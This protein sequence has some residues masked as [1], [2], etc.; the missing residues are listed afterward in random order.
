MIRIG[1][2]A[3]ERDKINTALFKRHPS[4]REGR[5]VCVPVHVRGQ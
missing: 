1:V 2:V 4:M 3:F 5:Q